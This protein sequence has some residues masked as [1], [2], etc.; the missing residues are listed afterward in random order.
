MDLK[1]L[2]F[3]RRR[4]QNA[5]RWAIVRQQCGLPLVPRRITRDEA[6]R[7]QRATPATTASAASSSTTPSSSSQGHIITAMQGVQSGPVQLQIRLPANDMAR[8]P[9]TFLMNMARRVQDAMEE[10]LAESQHRA[11]GA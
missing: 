3:R 8:I 11:G 6:A 1:R 2:R 5:I 7:L 9:P 4:V 10:V